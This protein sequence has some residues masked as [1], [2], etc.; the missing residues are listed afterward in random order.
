MK[1]EGF[2]L[3]ALIVFIAALSVLMAA[4][5]PVY[6]MQAQR[7]LEEELI[8]R[9]EEHVRAIQKY[10]RR[11]GIYPP[12]IEA[13]L[14]TNGIRFLRRQY[15]D[16]ISEE[17]FRL[18]T[19]NPDGSINGSTLY[20]QQINNV[21]LFQGGGGGAASMFGQPGFGQAG[22]SQQGRGGG[23]QRGSGQAGGG[24]GG[25]PQSGA[26][27]GNQQ[28]GRGQQS[29]L[30]QQS[31]FGQQAGFGAN[32]GF[33]QPGSNNQQNRGPQ[34][35]AGQQSGSGQQSGFGSPV[36]FGQQ[37]GA[38]SPGGFGQPG[39]NQQ[40]RGQQSGFGQAGF[41]QQSGSGQQGRGGQQSGGQRGGA[42]G[43]GGIQQPGGQRGGNN[44][45]SQQ[46]QPAAFGAQSQPVAG[47]GII[48]VAPENED[49]SLKA[50]NNREKY[51]EWEFIAILGSGNNPGAV[52]GSQGQTPNGQ[53]QQFQN[54]G[55]PSSG[56]QPNPFGQQQRGSGRPP[57]GR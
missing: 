33:G 30:G 16:P 34:S 43:V 37:S 26:G 36:G 41:G 51:N 24:R 44:R 46:G 35:G 47:G 20:Q 29:G 50:Y 4:S 14:E 53:L 3:A 23:Q 6:Q 9:G 25:G 49:V 15:V 39:S 2:A 19:I 42:P 21:P 17:G 57:G 40:S 32:A 10:Q 52:P 31:G 12:S 56:G 54:Q 55:S 18:L 38:G 48:G 28:G 13:L 5:A 45:G 8:F 7:E 27:Q 22:S 11:F 1:Q